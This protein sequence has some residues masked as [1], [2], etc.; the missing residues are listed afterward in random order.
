MFNNIEFTVLK[1]GSTNSYFK[2]EQGM[3]K[4]CALSAYFFL[5]AIETLAN[6]I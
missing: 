5:V 1:N 6:K 4:G 2:L 3:R